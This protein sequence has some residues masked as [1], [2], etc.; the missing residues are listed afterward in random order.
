MWY[1]EIGATGQA[2]MLNNPLATVNR[3]GISLHVQTP[4]AGPGKQGVFK[5]FIK[6]R[7]V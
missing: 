1:R 2:G 5:V 4:F 7:R 3:I 6:F